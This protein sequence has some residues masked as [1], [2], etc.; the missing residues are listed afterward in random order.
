MQMP[1]SKG[2]DHIG[3][4]MEWEK[5]QY[6]PMSGFCD[7]EDNDSTSAALSDIQIKL[8]SF[9][10]DKHIREA[11]LQNMQKCADFDSLLNICAKRIYESTKKKLQALIESIVAYG[12]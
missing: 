4:M 11:L 7:G 2:S 10:D 12:I 5:K 1:T 6:T 9:S 3:D 8:S